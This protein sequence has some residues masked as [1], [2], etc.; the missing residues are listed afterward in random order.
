[1]GAPGVLMKALS[2]TYFGPLVHI[3][4]RIPEKYVGNRV[5]AFT[6]IVVW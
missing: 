2:E 6:C 4:N 1:M 3:R 5:R